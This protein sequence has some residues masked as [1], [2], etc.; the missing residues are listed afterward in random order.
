M[1]R[2]TPCQSL[3]RRPSVPAS[4]GREWD[5][6][7]TRRADRTE[8]CPTGGTELDRDCIGLLT[9]VTGAKECGR[10]GRSW[11]CGTLARVSVSRC[12]V[13]ISRRFSWQRMLLSTPGE[14]AKGRWKVLAV[15]CMQHVLHPE[16]I[17]GR[18]WWFGRAGIINHTAVQG[19]PIDLLCHDL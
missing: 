6:L 13:S 18:E 3:R 12:P 17:W 1:Q 4:A 5:T 14:T 7:V 11:L 15:A 10:G 16:H 19:T 8:R 2:A 9:R